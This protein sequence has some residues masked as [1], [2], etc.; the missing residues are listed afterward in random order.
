MHAEVTAAMAS[1]RHDTMRDHHEA[2]HAGQASQI[3]SLQD[4]LKQAQQRLVAAES[5]VVPLDEVPNQKGASKKKRNVDVYESIGMV[6]HF[7]H[8]LEGDMQRIMQRRQG[9]GGSSQTQKKKAAWQDGPLVDADAQLLANEV[10][11]EVAA[12]RTTMG[13]HNSAR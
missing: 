2:N 12:L 9:R 4:E 7:M 5:E 10:A 8:S 6:Q 11:K 1:H 3:E 13:A